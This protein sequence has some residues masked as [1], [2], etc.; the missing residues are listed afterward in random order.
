MKSKHRIQ[1]VSLFAILFSISGATRAEL[2]E[3][4]HIQETGEIRIEVDR[5]VFEEFSRM[6]E[7]GYPPA[8]VMMHAVSTGMS[9]NDI[10][11]I[12]VKSNVNRA[13]EFYDTAES[14]L[15]ALPG[16]VC[17]ANRDDERYTRAVDP[18]DLGENPTVRQVAQAFFEENQRVV[19]FPNWSQGRVHMEASVSELAELVTDEQ[20]YVAGESD[21]SPRT[22]P[23]RP[24]FISLYRHNG[25]IIVDSGFDR[26]RRAQEQGTERLPVVLVYNDSLHR[27]I[28]NYESNVTVSQLA[29]DFYGEGLQLTAVPEWQVGDHHKSASVEELVDL[30]DVPNREDIQED[31]WAAVEQEIRGNGM[32]LPR[33]LLLTLV[34]SGQGNAWV[35]DPTMVAVASEMGVESLPVVLFYHEIDRQPCGQPSNC[36]DLLCEAATAAGATEEVCDG[37]DSQTTAGGA[38]GTQPSGIGSPDVVKG[39]AGGSQRGETGIDPHLYEGLSYTQNQC[40]S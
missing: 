6:F 10:L 14:L 1:V 37:N 16:W 19:P 2:G 8:T 23:N 38:L 4:T 29:E 7:L 34:R 40:T 24:V 27:S 15:P 36:E 17:Q 33:P 31:R 32:A 11:Y 12:A 28:S 35:D 39:L 21:G 22:T 18:S 5:Q 9:I 25:G 3:D 13:K 20:W 26:I 30:V